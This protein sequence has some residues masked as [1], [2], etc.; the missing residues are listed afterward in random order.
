[1]LYRYVGITILILFC[2]FFLAYAKTFPYR[3]L[4]YRRLKIKTVTG[5]SK[6]KNVRIRDIIFISMICLEAIIAVAG[7]LYGRSMLGLIAKVIGIAV[8]YSGAI[9]MILAFISAKK[10]GF[11]RGN[12]FP[13]EDIVWKNCGIYAYCRNPVAVAYILINVG[14]TFIFFNPVIFVLTVISIVFIHILIL[15]DEKDSEALSCNEYE[16]YRSLVHRYAGRGKVTI[17]KIR[18]GAYLCLADFAFFYYFI[19]IAYVG[20]FFTMLWVWPLL[21]VFSVFMFAVLSVKIE[22][23]DR[24]RIPRWFAVAYRIFAILFILIFVIIESLI[25]VKMNTKPKENM[26]YVIVLGAG[27]NGTVPSKPLM[28]RIDKAYEYMTDNP[29]T[30]LIASGGQGNNE[31][32]SEA[33]CIMKYLT[34]KGISCDRIILEERSTSTEENI[35]YSFEIIGDTAE[36]VGVISNG[37][38]LFRTSI[39]CEK[40]NHTI[41]GIPATTLFPMGIHYIV[42]EFFGIL[43]VLVFG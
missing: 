19:C 13:I 20:P 41:V 33:E 39:I 24:Y 2:F 16:E 38:H 43:F 26:D 9:V 35:K 8:G 6:A 12:I 40:Q 27:V 23:P 10:K 17:D 3:L 11:S 21:F 5:D 36:N 4:F 29:E 1:M 7:S 31:D 25:I 14:V 34:D 15:E 37:F 18:R 42:R 32:I 28:A 30:I 22:K